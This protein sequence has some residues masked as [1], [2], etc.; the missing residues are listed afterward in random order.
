[1][2][3]PRRLRSPGPRHPE[4]TKL[5][6]TA[7]AGGSNGYRLRLWKRELAAL[8]EDTGLAITVCH[9]PPGTSKLNRIEHR[10]FSHISMNWAGQPLTSHEVA[11]SLIAATTIRT[12]LSFHAERDTGSYPR[13]IRILDRE[14]KALT[15]QHLTPHQWHGEWNYTCDMRSHTASELEDGRVG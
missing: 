9:M 8:A 11:V 1:M 5:L 12:G 13:G 14:M 7:D 15:T 4:A 6:I 10:L 3:C 2:E